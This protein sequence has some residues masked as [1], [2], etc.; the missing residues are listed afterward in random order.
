MIRPLTLILFIIRALSVHAGDDVV[1]H[2]IASPYQY[3]STTIRVLLPDKIVPGETYQ[4]LYILPP[5]EMDSRSQKGGL[6]EVMKYDYQNKYNLICV[7]PEFTSK[8]WYCNHASDMGRQDESHFL[9]TVIPFIDDHYP[10]L[11]TSEGRLL[12][13][14]SKSGWGAFSLLLRNPEMFH[15]A[16][17]WDSGIRVDT[18]P[19]SEEERMQRI[20][21]LFGGEE[22][23]EKYR[24]T[25]LLKQRGD[26]LGDQTRLF[27]YNTE[28]K[29]GPGG[30]EIHKLMVELEI[31]HLYLYEPHRKHSWDSGWIPAAVRFL[32]DDY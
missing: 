12:M 29:R 4:V 14:F 11:K 24:L 5:G 9:K 28:G 16:V 20:D 3:D 15:K 30:A 2:P 1:R 8:P 26:Q 10:T 13:G 31:P 18:G 6:H 22:N 23:F 27:Y 7:A 25:T 17:G 32:V 19:I 21:S